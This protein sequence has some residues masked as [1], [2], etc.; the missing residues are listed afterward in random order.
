MKLNAIGTIQEIWY[1][2]FVGYIGFLKVLHFIHLRIMLL[3]P[4][5]IC[6]T[7]M[8]PKWIDNILYVCVCKRRNLFVDCRIACSIGLNIKELR[9]IFSV[10]NRKG[11]FLYEHPSFKISVN[12][13]DIGCY[14]KNTHRWI[15]ISVIYF[16][17]SLLLNHLNS[18]VLLRQKA[19]SWLTY[20]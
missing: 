15:Y 7:S 19:L 3:S 12:N 11:M 17:K 20:L 2:R 13:I 4:K 14:L 1:M 10:H 9:D 5:A 8:F 16:K 6:T 18:M